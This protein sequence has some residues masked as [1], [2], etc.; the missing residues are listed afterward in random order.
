[1]PVQSA[2]L[3]WPVLPEDEISRLRFALHVV[4]HR[5]KHWAG[6]PMPLDDEVLIVEPTYS[7]VKG[8][9]EIMPKYVETIKNSSEV[10]PEDDF[11]IRNTFWSIKYHTNITIVEVDGK[12]Q[13]LVMPR[14]TLKMM[15]HT[16]GCSDAW[17]MEQEQQAL[18]LL[19]TLISPRSMKQYF[20]TGQ[21]L[22]TSKRSG[23]VYIFRRLR[24]TIAL[25]STEKSSRILACL[26]MHPIA[27]YDGTWA[28]AMCPTDDLI[29]HLMLMRADE[30]M[31]WRRSNQ[32]S[33]AKIEAGMGI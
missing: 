32:H 8:M 31:Y 22:E 21:F 24:P 1:M 23:I 13:H 27:Y 30:H 16:M 19:A 17:G 11:E 18:N 9:A 2:A 12:I 10:K 6:I 20:L 4:S 28:G 29:A 15:I 7:G 25:R 3:P 5:R 33:S 14:H 26:C